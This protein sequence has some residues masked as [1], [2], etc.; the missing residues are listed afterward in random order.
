MTT[1]EYN[2]IL[3]LLDNKDICDFAGRMCK[4]GDVDPVTDYPQCVGSEIML[5]AARRHMY[6]SKAT[7]L[8]RRMIF[9][10][11]TG[12]EVLRA[13][14]YLMVLMK[15]IENNLDYKGC[16]KALNIQ[17]LERKYNRESFFAMDVPIEELKRVIKRD[18]GYYPVP[19]KEVT[20]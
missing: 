12:L 3:D 14:E 2:T 4:K 5:S 10:G 13:S 18:N 6:L 7:D 19:I 1:K 8:L 17:E 20:T 16:E 11:A 15:S 9:L